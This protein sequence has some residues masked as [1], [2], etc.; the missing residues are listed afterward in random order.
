[1]IPVLQLLVSTR[2]GGGPAHVRALANGLPAH[3]FRSLVAAPRDGS[4][5]DRL[6]ADGVEVIEMPANRVAA[7]ALAQLV[8]LVRT[9]GVRVIHSHGK[10]AGLYGRLA[11]RATGIPAVHTFHGIHYETYGPLRRAAYL[12]LE[13]RLSRWT[14]TV[15]SVSRAEEAEG[16]AL[17]LFT[18]AQSRVV[19]NGVDLTRLDAEALPREAARRQL[20]LPPDARVVGAVAR[21]DRVKRLDVLVLAMTRVPDAVAV[22]VGDGDEAPRLRELARAAGL[23]ERVR[24]TG[25]IPDAW[26]IMRA[27]DVY[28]APAAKEGMPIAVLEAMAVGLPVVASDIPPHRETLGAE[29]GAL[30]P[31]TPEGLAGALARV[32]RDPDSTA[33]GLANSARVRA[34]FRLERMLEGVAWVYTR[35]CRL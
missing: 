32:L 26:R 5:F 28:A 18:P 2:P 7:R 16:L 25:E 10:G 35:A 24:F 20:G 30:A 15:I 11:A 8:G 33:M 9:G 12:A 31:G 29:A 4:V 21:F 22:L 17:Q 27:F 1:V 23:G 34:E 19:P 13:R 6:R 14:S 3:G